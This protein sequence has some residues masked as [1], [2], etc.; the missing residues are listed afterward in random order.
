M[1]TIPTFVIGLGGV[2]NAVVR[3]LR[4]RFLTTET[5]GVPETVFLRS[6]D[7]ASE[8]NQATQAPY[9]PPQ[10]YTKLGDFNA[11]MV[12]THLENYPHIARWWHYPTGSYAPGFIDQGA[13]A[14]RPVGRLCFFQQFTK[15]H[16]ALNADFR[17]AIGVDMQNKL[18]QK[19]LA[20]VAR[21]PRVFIVGSLAGGT[22]S[23]MFI[24][25]AILARELLSRCGYITAGTRITGMF[26][27]PSVV[28]LA[29]KDAD[30]ISGRQRRI[31]S[32]AALTEMDFI[33]S[34]KNALSVQYPDPLGLVSTSDALFNMVTLF[35][36]TKHG[37]HGFTRQDE[38]LVRAAHALYAQISQGTRENLNTV[39]DNVKDHLDPSQQQTL[40]GQPATYCTFGVE[41]LEIPRQQLLKTWCREIGGRVGKLVSEF[42]WGTTRPQNLDTVMYKNLPETFKA[43]SVAF[44]LRSSSP[45]D[46]TMFPELSVF[47]QL[48]SDIG[49]SEKPADLARALDGFE[50]AAPDL[51]AAVVRA[52]GR[53]PEPAEEQE[54]LDKMVEQLVGSP[55]FR[56]GGAK[57][58]MQHMNERLGQLAQA[59]GIATMSR[60]DVEKSCKSGLLGKKADPTPALNWARARITQIAFERLRSAFGDQAARF[61]QQAT[62][63]AERLA[64]LQDLVRQETES[65]DLGREAGAIDLPPEMWLIEPEAIDQAVRANIDAVTAEVA[66]GVAGG[67][68]AFAADNFRGTVG[69]P[70]D[71]ALRTLV[72]TLVI[73]WTEL[74]AVRK[75]KRPGDTEQRLQKRMKACSPLVHMVDDEVELIEVMGS[76][77]R[78][79]RLKMVV[80]GM[81][82]TE[83]ASL[84]EWARREK[85]T[86]GNENAFQV[87]ASDDPLRDD[88]LNVEIG[89]PLC[90]MREVKSC[91]R[92][93]ESARIDDPHQ[94]AFTLT[95]KELVGIE[96]H[97]FMPRKAE[98]IHDMF[99]AAWVLDLVKI[100]LYAGT[101]SFAPEIFGDCEPVQLSEDEALDKS[102]LLRKAIE[103]FRRNELMP[104]FEKYFNNETAANRRAFREALLAAVAAKQVNL[105]ALKSR[106]EL[107]GLIGELGRYCEQVEKMTKDIV[108]L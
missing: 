65:L 39:M 18:A 30:T 53:L 51:G 67:L 102:R 64:H 33:L 10:M 22:C 76:R 72:R 35:T 57:R 55:D 105:E 3:I 5:G 71:D 17:Q 31:N 106:A 11:G 100:D 41:W 92:I 68:G 24:D 29:S 84:D 103:W 47:S 43:Y 20:E 28:H 83:R 63:R 21:T 4:Q 34:R 75:T 46:L 89:W 99:A 87:I 81:E 38:V 101:I 79:V 91:A 80:T 45:E 62:L 26:A 36:D 108:D 9:L 74:A 61:A 49:T 85:E 42:E 58:F 66:Q 37:G 23:G 6:I 32:H 44:R 7:T 15:I 104:K 94:A 73:E 1:L 13:G 19:G 56:I 59:P 16:D 52:A 96:S 95:M 48:I 78:P 70:G 77:R 90:L 93:F 50:L 54:W 14:R 25:T 69:S 12:V 98:R 88:V 60:A 40:D 86:A 8:T 82:Q 97:T 27:L 107:K 2:G